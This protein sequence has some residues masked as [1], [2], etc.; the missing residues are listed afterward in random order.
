MNPSSDRRIAEFYAQTY[1][2]SVPDWP[3]EIDFYRGLASHL[4]AGDDGLLEVACGTGRVA[5]RLAEAGSRVTG[6]D[7]SPEMI[8]QA[9]ANSR[10][11]T[12]VRWVQADMRGFGLGDTYGLVVIPGHAFQNLNEAQEQVACLECIRRHLKPSGKLVVHLDHQD[13]EWLGDLVGKK[14]GVFEPAEEFREPR[15]G[16]QIRTSRAWNFQPATQ[17]AV[18]TTR[19][20]AIG[21]DGQVLDQWKTEPIHLH[22]VFRFEMEH[23]L[24]R[25]GFDVEAVYGDFFKAPLSNQS[26]N[27]IWVAVKPEKAA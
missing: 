18:C 3:G 19:W 5:I 9:R 20:E 24:A 15:S 1:D 7:I 21:A 2:Q 4:Q 8:E 12:N 14:G 26:A 22:C 16:R 6:L 23:L 17:T 25:T 10:G 11:L 27:M 13:F